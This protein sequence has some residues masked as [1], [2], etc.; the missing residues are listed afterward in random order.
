MMVSPAAIADGRD[1]GLAPGNAGSGPYD[2]VSY[3]PGQSL[4]VERSATPHWNPELGKARRIELSFVGDQT[5]RLNA[6]RAGDADIVFA[7]HDGYPIVEDMVKS[8]VALADFTDNSAAGYGI[9]W[10]PTGDLA[11]PLVRQAANLAVDR[12]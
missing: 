8:G 5:A 7:S 4:I 3:T 11:D 10:R 9:Q 2:V 6:L 1:L 12:E